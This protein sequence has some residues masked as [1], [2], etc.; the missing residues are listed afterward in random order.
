MNMVPSRGF[1]WRLSVPGLITLV[2]GVALLAWLGIPAAVQAQSSSF[3][4]VPASNPYH[5]QIEVLAELGVV[6]GEADGAFHPTEAVTREEFAKMLVVAMRISASTTDQCS[7]ADVPRSA[8]ND[9]YP[10]HYIAA[11]AAKGII[12]GYVKAGKSTFR[13]YAPITLAELVTMGTRASGRPLKQVPAGYKSSWGAFNKNLAPYVN[14]AQYNGLLQG[15]SLRTMSPW[16]SATREEAAAFLFNLMGT[17]PAGLNGRFLGTAADLADYFRSAGHTSGKFTV[18]LDA[19][20]KLYVTYGS[21][22]GIRA[23]MAWAQMIHETGFGNY[24]GD[25]NPAQNNFA[26][27][28]AVGGGAPGNSFATAELGVIAQYVHLACYLYPED[29]PDPYFV[30]STDPTK[31]GDPRYFTTASRRGSVRTVFDLDGKWAVP[32]NGYGAAIQKYAD[33]VMQTAGWPSAL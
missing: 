16:R 18:S 21:R 2:L 3:S 7:F 14:E 22:F 28:G 5:L 25:V 31:P 33:G 9:L 32:G 17:D 8:G 6:G 26:G 24:G 30:C 29:L 23:D 10:D 11:A 12:T 19:L 20:A 15:F 4:D 27:I 1:S 13:P